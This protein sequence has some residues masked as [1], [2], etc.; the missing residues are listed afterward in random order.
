MQMTVGWNSGS[1]N[2][3]SGSTAGALVTYSAGSGYPLDLSNKQFSVTIKDGNNV[4]SPANV[5]SCCSGSSITILMP[6][7]A[8]TAYFT[9]NF[10]GPTG[11]YKAGDYVAYAANTGTLSLIS[12]SNL[13]VGVNIITLNITKSVSNPIASIMLVSKRSADYTIPVSNWTTNG[14]QITLSVLLTTGSFKFVVRG[15]SLFYTMNDMINVGMP[16][17]IIS[18]AESY[19]YN[20]GIFTI[21]ASDLSPISNIR[22]NGLKGALIDYNQNANTATYGIPSFVTTLSQSTYNLAK[23]ELLDLSMATYFNDVTTNAKVGLSFDGLSTTYYSSPNSACWIGIDFGTSSSASISRMR[24]FPNLNWVNTASKLLDATFEGSNDG[25]SWNTLAT[26]DQTIHSGWNTLASSLTTP[27]R[28][29]RFAHNNASKCN[30]A[31]IEL[32]GIVYSNSNPSDLTSQPSDIV[33]EDGYNTYTFPSTATYTAARTAVVNSFSPRYGDT[34]GGYTLNI[35]GT[36]LGFGTPKVLI[37]GIVCTSPTYDSATSSITCVV[38]ARPKIP[39]SSSI[40]VTIGNSAAI[41]R[42]TFYYVLRWSDT[43]TWGTDLP[44]IDGDLISIPAGM[45]L[46]VDQDTPNLRG[47]AVSNATIIFSDEKDLTINTGFI[48]VVGGR[49]IAGT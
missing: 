43:R 2:T 20:G 36:N 15:S 46:L 6:P 14:T 4:V 33:Y 31:E 5:V 8:D 26:V 25:N 32:Y 39:A 29:V 28:Y 16:T 10:A 35:T 38:G 22:V 30:I 12:P 41:L 47:I 19:S 49:F 42:A 37:D 18:T 48:T 23:T 13:S 45:T 3:W 1:Q 21:S 17:N 7:A 27:Y 44:P 24:L 34:F 11:S 9:I 40:T